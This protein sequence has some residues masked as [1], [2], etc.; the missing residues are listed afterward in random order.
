VTK[1]TV[2]RSQVVPA[3]LAWLRA[4][5]GDADA[6]AK[7]WEL[8]PDVMTMREIVVPLA[9]VHGV[10][11]DIAR[12]LG[13]PNFGLHVG[14][15]MPRGSYGLIEYIGRSA[16]TVLA[17]CRRVVR[18]G[19]LLNET[20]TLA[21]E[22]GDGI[23]ILSQRTP[24]EPLVGGRHANEM[25][26][27]LVVRV[28]RELTSARGAIRGVSFAHPA[29]P[30]TS[31]HSAFFECPIEF[32]RGE[33]RVAFASEFLRA[34]LDGADEALLAVLDEQAERIIASQPKK[35]DELTRIREQVR[36]AVKDGQ[37]SLERIAE[38]M[39]ASPRTLQ[40]RLADEGTNF[41]QVVDDVR[42]EL[43]RHYMKDERLAIGEI[44]YLL[45]FSE[46]SAFSR[47]F[48]RWTGKTPAAFR[49]KD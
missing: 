27:A 15:K 14:L 45:G 2:I 47:A 12:A 19:G 33:N 13:D 34:K 20:H 4:H 30:D 22:E 17:A 10:S 48:K 38:L 36:V 11:D 18:Y 3:F 16:P 42:A 1:P 28:M 7:K 8:P 24:G 44:A 46:L 32:G 25:F 21:F 31:E 26:I 29:P 49:K 6:I 41:N 43:A 9:T 5:G 40:R 23:S 37:P 35:S 39:H